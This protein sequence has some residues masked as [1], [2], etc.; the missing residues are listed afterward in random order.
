MTIQTLRLRVKQHRIL[1]VVIFQVKRHCDDDDFMSMEAMSDV[2]QHLNMWKLVAA[3][4][5]SYFRVEGG[6]RLMVL[7][8]ECG[9]FFLKIIIMI[10]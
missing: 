4:T 10:Y 6:G 1:F 9:I 8:D 5:L 2:L 3:A 7:G